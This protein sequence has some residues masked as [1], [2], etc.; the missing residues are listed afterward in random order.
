MA[1][2][3]KFAHGRKENVEQAIA[4]GKIDA[5]DIVIFSNTDDEFGYVSHDKTVKPIKSRTNEDYVL[6]GTSIGALNDGDVI[7]AGTS[8][9][10]LLKLIVSKPVHPTYIKPTVAL[11]SDLAT[12]SYEV[13]EAISPT[14]TA[15]F[16]KNDGGELVSMKIE[17]D[18]EEI[19]SG[20]SD[21]LQKTYEFTVEEEENTFIATAEFLDGEIKENNLGEEDANGM[22]LAGSVSSPKVKIM[23][24]Y[25]YFCG[26]SATSDV[27]ILYLNS[28]LGVYDNTVITINVPV[29][30]KTICFAYPASLRDISEVEYVE[31]NDNG[32]AENFDKQLINYTLPN[33]EEIEYKLYTYEMGVCAAAKMTIKA[34][35]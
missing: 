6:N 14:F 12:Y 10:D 8:I 19:E 24:K 25:K 29:G 15:S 26:T 30:A 3:V 27:D 2:D 32:M 5:D 35:V 11:N 1:Y 31:L 22:I 17:K 16:N 28:E 4:A 20:E 9:D 23:G 7:P 21:V 18:S 34:T 33:G 13:G